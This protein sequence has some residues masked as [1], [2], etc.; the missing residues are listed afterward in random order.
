MFATRNCGSVHLKGIEIHPDVVRMIMG[1][2]YFIG[3]DCVVFA[4]EFIAVAF[5]SKTH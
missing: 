1:N 2:N 3:P 5:F 4:L